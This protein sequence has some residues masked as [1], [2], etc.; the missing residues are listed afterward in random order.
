MAQLP[1]L[2]KIN[3]PVKLEGNVFRVELRDNKPLVILA[4]NQYAAIEKYKYANGII[5]TDNKFDVEAVN[6]SDPAYN[7]AL[8]LPDRPSDFVLTG[9][10]DLLA[11]HAQPEYDVGRTG[12]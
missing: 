11:A 5:Q 9:F 10:N 2:H 7:E 12:V 4:D 1:D 3:I 6:E 8:D